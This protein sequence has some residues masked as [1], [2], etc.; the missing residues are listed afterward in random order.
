VAPILRIVRYF[1]LWL[2][3]ENPPATADWIVRRAFAPRSRALVSHINANNYYWLAR[4]PTI[5]E[6]LIRDGVLLLDGIG[7]KVGGYL[8]GHAH[9]PDLNGTDLFPLVMQRGQHRGLR[10]FLLGGRQEVVERAALNIETHYPGVRVVG[11]RDGYFGPGEEPHVVNQI[12]TSQPRILLIGLG[13]LR[14]EQFALRYRDALG[15]PLIWNV[16]GLFDFVSEAK[17]RAPSLLRR[18]KLEWL[19]R[20]FLEPR[21]MWYRNLVAAPWFVA[22]LVRAYMRNAI[23]QRTSPLEPLWLRESGGKTYTRP[24]VNIDVMER[25]ALERRV[26]ETVDAPRSS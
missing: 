21:T 2:L 17:P 10:V 4:S 16:G 20:F 7:L 23:H 15:V 25:R 18:F 24:D 6:S 13:F 3:A 26:E 12:L 9:L 19:F 1:D 22:H 11:L 14:Q 8:L 5:R